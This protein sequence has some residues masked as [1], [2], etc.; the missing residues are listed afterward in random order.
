MKAE[1]DET[2]CELDIAKD[3]AKE[4]K[5][6]GIEALIAA[7]GK[8]DLPSVWDTDPVLWFCQCESSSGVK[9]DHICGQAA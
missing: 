3:R 6:D 5:P 4:E 2:Q 8:V 7:V 9:F 1:L